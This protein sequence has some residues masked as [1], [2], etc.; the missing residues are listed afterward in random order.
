MLEMYG[1]SLSLTC[2][3]CQCDSLVLNNK[4]KLKSGLFVE[5]F[6]W[7][8]KLWIWNLASFVENTFKN[9]LKQLFGAFWDTS[10]PWQVQPF[11]YCSSIEA[12]ACFSLWYLTQNLIMT[13]K[14]CFYMP[15]KIILCPFFVFEKSKWQTLFIFQSLQSFKRSC[16]HD[17]N[18]DRIRLHLADLCTW[19]WL[20]GKL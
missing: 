1:F 13:I 12:A 2:T 5:L 4:L 8:N 15:W 19:Q 14:Q 3:F 20:S 9:N 7:H 17:I 10:G 16:Q 6:H 18:A 11:C